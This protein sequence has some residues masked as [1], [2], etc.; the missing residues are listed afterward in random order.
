MAKPTEKELKAVHGVLYKRSRL[1]AISDHINNVDVL[2]SPK[3]GNTGESGPLWYS[4]SGTIDG[5]Q[6]DAANE[7]RGLVNILLK[8]RGELANVK[9]DK[10]DRQQLM[11][12]L[13]LQADAWTA[14]ADSYS[15]PNPPDPL[16]NGVK[17]I[18]QSLAAH[19]RA[20]LEASLPVLHYLRKN[21]ELHV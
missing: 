9:F 3:Q 7:C 6:L 12:A 10:Q 5:A 16:H 2:M 20:C 14:R 11:K 17:Q 19:Q 1:R 8:I 4:G 18:V 21:S 15:N 13:K